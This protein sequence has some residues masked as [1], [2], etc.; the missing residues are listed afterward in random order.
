M[1]LVAT[2]IHPHVVFKQVHHDCTYVCLH[3]RDR[4]GGEMG[5]TEDETYH[6]IFTYMYIPPTTRAEELHKAYKVT[7]GISSILEDIPQQQPV[8][9]LGDLNARVG[10][11]QNVI[12]DRDDC[13]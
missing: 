10:N 5:N 6:F 3:L 13:R 7:E 11:W 1:I 9:V 12:F 8:F 4:H 2:A